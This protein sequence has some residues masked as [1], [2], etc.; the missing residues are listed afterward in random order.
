MKRLLPLLALLASPAFAASEVSLASQVLVE[1]V[2]Q[3]AG[4][5]Q[6]ISFE[7]PKV[8]MPGDKLMF[9]V[10]YKN[11]GREPAA[12]FTVTNP[13]P[14]S[15]TYAGGEGE[16]LSVSSDGGKNWGDLAAL[17][18]READGTLRPAEPADVTHVRWKSSRAIA[19]GESGKLSFRGT[20]R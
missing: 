15:V 13:I 7:P 1:R 3:D 10:S 19:P 11:E 2:K 4:G 6:V 14:Q 9:V 8:V 12:E 17:T 20:V 5:K 16:W 18:V